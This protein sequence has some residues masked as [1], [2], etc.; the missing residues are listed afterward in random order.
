MRKKGLIACISLL[1]LLAACQKTEGEGG[2]SSITGYVLVNDY[3]S[4]GDLKDIYYAPN[5]TIYI[6]YGDNSI[7]DD[8]KRTSYDGGYKFTDLFPGNYKMFAYSKCDTCASG[9][10]P[11]F[12]T[13]NIEHKGMKVDA[14]LITIKK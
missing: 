10:E 6:I 13:V 1:T 3:D 12:A 7:Y 2:S 11:V 9:V 14:P 4:Q 5:E 8:S